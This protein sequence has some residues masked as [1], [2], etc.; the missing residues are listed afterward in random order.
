MLRVSTESLELAPATI[1]SKTTSIDVRF[2]GQRIWSLDVSDLTTCDTIAAVD[3]TKQDTDGT[4]NATSLRVHA[5]LRAL[6]PTALKPHLTGRTRLSI[7]DSRTQE[8]LAA[9]ELSFDDQPT[10]TQ[11]ADASGRSLMVNKW[12]R[13]GLPLE[14]IGES[15]E[16][17]LVQRVKQILKDLSDLRLRPFVVGG[18]LLGA[19]RDGKLLPHDDDAD[20]AYLSVHTD[21]SDI[22]LEG[23]RVGHQLTAM[24][25]TVLHH[26][27]T[28]LQILFSGDENDPESYIDVFAAF[29]TNDGYINQPF[30]VRGPMKH[31]E[32]LPFSTVV[33]NDEALPAPADVNR[34]LTINYDENWRTPLPGFKI[35][36]P[37]ET[38]ERFEPWFGGFNF[39]REFWD[40]H[41][42]LAPMAPAV[43]SQADAWQPGRDWLLQ[44]ALPTTN[45]IDL[46]CGTGTLTRELAGRNQ[47]KQL[48][49][50]D[51]SA[52]ALEQA[53]ASSGE[54]LSFGEINLNRLASIAFARDFKLES[55]YSLIAN[56]L[57]EQIG[58]RARAHVWRIARM[59]LRSGGSAHLTFFTEPR[60]DVSPQD[61]TSWHLSVDQARDE[62][63]S[64]GLSLK[65]TALEAAHSPDDQPPP[66]A[67]DRRQ[68]VGVTVQS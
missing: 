7:V 61:P 55:P 62:A 17:Q 28:H 6:W 60:T 4:E 57:V 29:F 40:D 56:H 23:F 58:H 66:F 31:N 44:H 16:I 42:G 24:G 34:W 9:S 39:Q 10:R 11:I 13:L 27:A 49:G 19:V 64:Y 2:D 21:P 54:N 14:S 37:Q 30:H 20:I 41:F 5:W 46:G 48:L 59:A 50:L 52:T 22:A 15:A 45:I 26:S 1:P 47:N 51:F 63:S 38:R 35:V 12:G 53:N 33:L 67:C 32:M 3:T 65:I 43:D 68:A 18:T 25:Y 8:E 36:T